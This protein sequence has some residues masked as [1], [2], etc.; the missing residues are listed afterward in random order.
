MIEDAPEPAQL[1]EGEDKGE[2]EVI[3]DSADAPPITVAWILEEPDGITKLDLQAPQVH[4]RITSTSKETA[5]VSGLWVVEHA[6]EASRVALQPFSLDAGATHNVSLNLASYCDL[7][8]KGAAPGAVWLSLLADSSGQ[9]FQEG[10]ESSIAGWIHPGTEALRFWV[11]GDQVQ[12]LANRSLSRAQVDG[13]LDD[14]TLL[15]NLYPQ[16]SPEDYADLQ[17]GEII[18]VVQW[19]PPSDEEQSMLDDLAEQMKGEG[20]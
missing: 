7:K 15:T 16:L 10:K 17:A 8:E 11:G 5:L 1:R 3:V 6:G 4:A 9:V 19:V 14:E 13:T 18:N 20:G 2:G 12:I